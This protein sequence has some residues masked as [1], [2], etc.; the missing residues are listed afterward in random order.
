MINRSC[1]HGAWCRE[2]RP[3]RAQEYG[4]RDALGDLVCLFLTEILDENRAVFT[5]AKQLPEVLQPLFLFNRSVH[6]FHAF[7]LHT[8]MPTSSFLRSSFRCR[9]I[10]HC[11]FMNIGCHIRY[12]VCRT[13]TR[14]TWRRKYT[15]EG[16]LGGSCP[17][18][19]SNRIK[20][21]GGQRRRQILVGRS[22]RVDRVSIAGHGELDL[23]VFAST[24][25]ELLE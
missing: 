9:I 10:D 17:Y 2:S 6:A 15:R 3:W 23:G 19:R 1:D 22:T 11:S 7:M 4:S 16:D 12:I 20:A 14:S 5:E 18:H 25:E 13:T 24:R 8:F 21:A